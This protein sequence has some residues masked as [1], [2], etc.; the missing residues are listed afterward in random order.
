MKKILKWGAIVF[1][2]LIAIGAIAGGRSKDSNTESVSDTEK[3]TSADTAETTRPEIKPTPIV[4]SADELADSFDANQVAAEKEWAGKYVQ[5]TAE[6]TNITDS[7]LSFQNLGS[8][9]FT[10][11]QISCRVSNKEQLL[12]LKNGQMVTARGVVGKQTIGVI[13]IKDCEVVEQ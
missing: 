7:G 2:V 8:K 11:T 4:I 9:E 1:V 12:S 3:S 13:D 6:V 10:L 5:F